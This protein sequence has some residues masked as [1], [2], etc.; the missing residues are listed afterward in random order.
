MTNKTHAKGSKGREHRRDQFSKPAR[1]NNNLL[2]WI[3]I[4]GLL[5]VVGYLVVSRMQS[6]PTTAT[7]SAKTIQLAAGAAH[8]RI[9]LSDV[10][11]GQAKFFEAS[12]PNNTTARFFVIKTSDGVYRAALDACEVCYGAGKGYYQDGDQMVCRKCGRHFSVNT[13]NNGTTGCH[14]IG[15]TRTVDGSD[16]LIKTSELESGSHY[17]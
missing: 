3:V 5:G 7:A 2:L 6:D 12:L 4:A 13:V 16:L 17:F 14:P 15:L 8:V 10:S 9:P 1:R 11:N